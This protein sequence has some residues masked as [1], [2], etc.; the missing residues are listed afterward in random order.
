MV[1]TGVIVLF[2][3]AIQN[4]YPAQFGLTKSG[5]ELEHAYY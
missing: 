5:T 1:K 2:F 3:E 4:Y